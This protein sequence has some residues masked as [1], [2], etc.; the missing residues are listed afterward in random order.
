[1]NMTSLYLY[2]II[3][4]ESWEH[5]ESMAASFTIDYFESKK[6]NFELD[7]LNWRLIYVARA[8]SIISLRERWKLGEQQTET[9]A[10]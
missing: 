6:I 7:K 5:V 1:M 3:T 4:S 2:I 8:G 9:V 10:G